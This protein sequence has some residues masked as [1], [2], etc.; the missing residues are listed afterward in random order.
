[1]VAVI[2]WGVYAA[3]KQDNEKQNFNYSRRMVKKQWLQKRIQRLCKT[4]KGIQSE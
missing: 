1:M 3:S 2:L 4:I